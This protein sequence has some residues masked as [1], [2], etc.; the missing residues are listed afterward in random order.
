VALPRL[1]GARLSE[2][3]PVV[4]DAPALTQVAPVPLPLPCVAGQEA[5]QPTDKT[6]VG[7]G[8]KPQDAGGQRTPETSTRP[9]RNVAKATGPAQNN[10][11]PV[12]TVNK[13]TSK[14]KKRTV[15][16]KAKSVHNPAKVVHSKLKPR[17]QVITGAKVPVITK[18]ITSVIANPITT[19]KI[20]TKRKPVDTLTPEVNPPYNMRSMS[21]SPVRTATPTASKPVGAP[22][23]VPATPLHLSR[24][25]HLHQL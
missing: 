9:V 8:A 14:I 2:E 4:V 7:E 20:G 12:T 21:K 19:T 10:V 24:W 5:L 1:E 15:P 17:P 18:A 13:I 6:V 25:E 16:V 22:A 3:Q 23:S 11:S